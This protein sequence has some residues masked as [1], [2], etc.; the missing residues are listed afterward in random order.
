MPRI[1]VV[2]ELIYEGEEEWVRKSLAK[3]TVKETMEFG[4]DCRIHS[5]L[6]SSE[7]LGSLIIKQQG[8]R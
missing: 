7:P 3:S 6:K 2:R 8:G 1:R 5:K 4:N